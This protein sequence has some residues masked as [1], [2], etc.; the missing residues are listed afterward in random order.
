MSL[1]YG[2]SAKLI[3]ADESMLIYIYSAFNWN[4]H[5]ESYR[6]KMDIKDGEIY[7]DQDTLIE[8]I[9]VQK[10]KRMPSGR[11]KIIEK[12][13]IQKVDVQA[14]YRLGKIKIKNASGTWKKDENGIDRISWYLIREMY[15]EYQETGQIPET[16]IAFW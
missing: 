14:L 7:I 15:K 13:L 6:K 12:K 2:G 1:G 11:K 9:I 16:V 5:E 8:P 4:I 3:E 10:M